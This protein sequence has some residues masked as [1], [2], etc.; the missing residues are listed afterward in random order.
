MQ[1]IN[2]HNIQHIHTPHTHNTYAQ[3]IHTT[4]HTTSSLLAL[5]QGWVCCALSYLKIISNT[6][7]TLLTTVPNADGA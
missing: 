2:T 1:H 6:L 4:Q 3:H 5:Y 7:L